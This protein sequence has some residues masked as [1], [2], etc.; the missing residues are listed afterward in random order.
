MGRKKQT[1]DL[2]A[3][4]GETNPANSEQIR[5]PSE[6]VRRARVAAAAAGMTLGGY[7]SSRLDAVMEEEIPRLL[8]AMN[9]CKQ[10]K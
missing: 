8:E 7:I 1:V 6:F 4:S 3:D 9:L 10:K 2:D 5:L